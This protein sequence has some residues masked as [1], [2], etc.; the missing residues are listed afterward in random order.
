MLDR[1]GI[2]DEDW[3]RTPASVQLAFTSL[4]HQLLMLEMRSD[5][6]ECQ[7]AQL[8]EQVAQVEDLK[9]ELADLRERL[10]QNPTTLL[11]FLQRIHLINSR[12]SPM[13]RKIESAADNGVI[14]GSL[15]NSKLWPKLIELL[16]SDQSAATGVVI[17]F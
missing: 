1:F 5:V 14:A 15:V 6:Y 3:Q 13:N 16:T 7:L 2:R 11:S 4:Y 8:R 10:S 9:A 17:C 12:L